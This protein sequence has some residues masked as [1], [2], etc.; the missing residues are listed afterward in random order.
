[1][2]NAAAERERFSLKDELHIRIEL[3]AW[4]TTN[5]DTADTFVDSFKAASLHES[6]L[7]LQAC[8]DGVDRVEHQ[9]D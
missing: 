3:T 2:K 6:L 4:R 7:R 1:M 8:F 5:T 9:V